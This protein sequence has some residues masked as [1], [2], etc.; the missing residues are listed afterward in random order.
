VWMDGRGCDDRRGARNGREAPGPFYRGRRRER[1]ERG[2]GGTRRLVVPFRGRASAAAKGNSDPRPVLFFRPRGLVGS[3]R[4]PILPTLPSSLPVCFGLGT[5]GGT[6]AVGL[7]RP[8]EGNVNNV[9][10]RGPRA[11]SRQRAGSGKPAARLDRV[12]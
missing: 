8:R 3:H 4:R 11:G 7:A 6:E 12:G 9:A 1:R 10:R 5:P 2:T